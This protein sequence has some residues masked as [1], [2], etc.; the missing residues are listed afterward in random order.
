[1]KMAII[2]GL[3][4]VA[5]LLTGFLAGRQANP[6]YIWLGE[7]YKKEAASYDRLQASLTGL[8]ES[9]AADAALQQEPKR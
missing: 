7:M 9:C 3:L 5:G 8:R 1:M 4:V 6:D 2:A